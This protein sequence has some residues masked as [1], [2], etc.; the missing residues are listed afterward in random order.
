MGS[1]RQPVANDG[2]DYD[3]F[4]RFSKAEPLPRIA[5]VCN[6][7]APQRLHTLL[8]A[9]ATPLA[10]R[11][12]CWRRM[13]LADREA[14]AH[15]DDYRLAERDRELRAGGSCEDVE[16]G[17]DEEERRGGRGRAFEQAERREAMIATASRSS[18]NRASKPAHAISQCAGPIRRRQ[19]EDP[20]HDGPRARATGLRARI[21]KRSRGA[22]ASRA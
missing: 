21:R 7:G 1:D 15:L 12:A 2:K 8:P 6:H 9:A 18:V 10:T 22:R 5:T 19:K 16:P 3:S 17:V 14:R 11:S 20:Q 13:R 4:C